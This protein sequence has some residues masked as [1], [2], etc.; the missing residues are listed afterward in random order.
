MKI[1]NFIVSSKR[2]FEACLE[3]YKNPPSIDFF[4]LSNC[5][6]SYSLIE[7]KLKVNESLL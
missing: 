2:Y 5:I 3:S 1:V 4:L 6:R 7:L